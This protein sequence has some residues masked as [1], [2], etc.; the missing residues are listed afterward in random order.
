MRIA[1]RNS[2]HLAV[3]K[4]TMFLSTQWTS[5]GQAARVRFRILDLEVTHSTLT[6]GKSLVDTILLNS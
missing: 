1:H 3:I 6:V 4:C 5:T 2:T